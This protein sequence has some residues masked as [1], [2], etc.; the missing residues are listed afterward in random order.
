MLLNGQDDSNNSAHRGHDHQSVEEVDW[1]AVGA[2]VVGP[3]DLG[4]ASVGC[5]DQH[6]REVALEGAVEP[7]EALYIQHVHLHKNEKSRHEAKSCTQHVHLDQRKN[8]RADVP[9]M[10]S[11]MCTC[12]KYN[13]A[14]PGDVPIVVP[15]ISSLRR[16]QKPTQN[17]RLNYGG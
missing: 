5:D 15:S 4:D 7:R 13:K 14:V 17:H 9:I 3:P 1:D 11:G 6:R 10:V 2:L 16:P 8:T 12:T